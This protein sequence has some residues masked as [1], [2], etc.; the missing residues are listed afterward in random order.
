M[1][2]QN[3]VTDDQ[4]C[5]CRHMPDGTELQ[6]ATLGNQIDRNLVT[7]QEGVVIIRYHRG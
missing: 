6:H 7:Y 5:S 4:A 3:L 2:G 1:A